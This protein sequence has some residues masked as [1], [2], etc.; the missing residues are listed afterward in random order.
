MGTDDQDVQQSRRRGRY[1]R[2]SR[3]QKILVLLVFVNGMTTHD[4]AKVADINEN[5]D[6]SIIKAYKRDGE[7]VERARGGTRAKKL[8]GGVLLLIKEVVETFTQHLG[9]DTRISQGRKNLDVSV[10]TIF[11]ALRKLQI[12][13]KKGLRKLLSSE[14]PIMNSGV[15]IVPITSNY[16]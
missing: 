15:S 1:S 10:T 7:I 4:A 13:L 12:T 16:I 9:A 8:T 2:V 14:T 6:R 3:N 11:S 5:T